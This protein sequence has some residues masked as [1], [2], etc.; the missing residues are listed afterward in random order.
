MTNPHLWGPPLW[1][2]LFACAWHG[3]DFEALRELLFVQLPLL[4]PCEKCR[5]HLV[6]NR[7][8]ATRKAGGEPRTSAQ[9]FR[10]LWFLKDEVNRSLRPRQPSIDLDDLRARYSLHGGVVDDVALGDALV[11]VALDARRRDLDDDFVRFCTASLAVLLPLP[12]DAELLLAL[13]AMQRPIVANAVRCA[14]ASRVERGLPPLPEAH[15]RRI[16]SLDD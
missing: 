16:A 10:W 5:H 1:Q 12:A 3:A 15:Y 2:C 4:L 13:R 8:A 6:A 14:K 7:P 9:A 11:L